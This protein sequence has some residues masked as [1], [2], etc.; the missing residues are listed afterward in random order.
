[1]WLKF[2]IFCVILRFQCSWTFSS[3]AGLSAC[4]T[5]TPNHGLNQPQISLSPVTITLSTQNVRQGEFLTVTLEGQDGFE[6]RGFM[7]QLRTLTEELNVVGRFEI[8]E[9]MRTVFCSFPQ[10]SVA[11]HTSATPRTKIELTWQAPTTF[12]GIANFQLVLGN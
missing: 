7:I 8:K 10:D 6:F 11:T 1:M 9:G 5:M 4:E 12:V 2:V 3:G